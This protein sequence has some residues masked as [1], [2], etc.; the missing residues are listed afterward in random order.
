MVACVFSQVDYSVFKYQVLAFNTHKLLDEL[1]LFIQVVAFYFFRN[2][3]DRIGEGLDLLLSQS[4]FPKVQIGRAS[5]RER[6]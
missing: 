5:C 3:L 6:V 2:R 4:I 1:I